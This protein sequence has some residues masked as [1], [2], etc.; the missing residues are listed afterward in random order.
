[1]L[2]IMNCGKISTKKEINIWKEDVQQDLYTVG[3]NNRHVKTRD[4]RQWRNIALEAK[5]QKGS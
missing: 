3:I 1:M 5:V 2:K 4:R